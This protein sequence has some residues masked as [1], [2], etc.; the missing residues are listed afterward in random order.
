MEVLLP[1]PTA[2]TR[3]QAP[4]MSVRPLI[5]I[6]T[7][8]F[9]RRESV[10]RAVESVRE[11]T[12]DGFEHIVID[13]CSEDGTAEM[14][15]GIRD[16]RI[17]VH[18]FAQRRG[19]NAARNQGVAMARAPVVTFLDSD[20]E[21]LPHRLEHVLG[22]LAAEPDVDVVLSSFRVCQ[23]GGEIA[24][25]NRDQRLDGPRLEEL[26]V[27]HALYLGGSSITVR[28]DVARRFAWTASLQRMQD[29]DLLLHLATNHR[30]GSAVQWVRI[31][32]GVDWTKHPSKDSISGRAE[33]F[34]RALG[35]L[36]AIHPELLAR[37]DLAVRY[38]VARQLKVHLARIQP[39]LLVAAL[40]E[41]ARVPQFGFSL[42]S[43]LTAYRY[44]RLMRRRMISVGMRGAKPVQSGDLVP[45]VSRALA[46]HRWPASF[47][48]R[49]HHGCRVAQR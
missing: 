12:M 34:V 22:I 5:T 45:R 43:L 17:R 29:R 13:D 23:A 19:A 46:V 6:V 36:M 28:R 11:Q 4:R 39:R 27:W 24:S 41:N 7:P 16:S 20:D 44:G 37:H 8:T 3:S 30:R 9:N 18:R 26:L 33:G 47:T 15:R 10:A 2:T 48:W 21:F 49:N 14:C 42:A 32:E 38:Q 35:D 1:F 31:I 40:G 25:V